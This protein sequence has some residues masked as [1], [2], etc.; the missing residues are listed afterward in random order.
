MDYALEIKSLG[1]FHNEPTEGDGAR[2]L[3]SEHLQDILAD[4]TLEATCSTI[5]KRKRLV[6]S[7]AETDDKVQ[8]GISN[9][10][11]ILQSNTMEAATAMQAP[12]D[13]PTSS[14]TGPSEPT[15]MSQ[16]MQQM[17]MATKACQISVK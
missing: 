7:E 12:L 5:T 3:A 13:N 14:G 1:N 17:Q 16:Q 10:L 6:I 8:T 15:N 9:A 11:Q 4:K 2:F